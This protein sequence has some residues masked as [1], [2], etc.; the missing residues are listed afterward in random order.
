[1]TSAVRSL[2]AHVPPPPPSQNIHRAPPP[3]S[4][5]LAED[6][7]SILEGAA[8]A[9]QSSSSALGQQ[10]LGPSPQQAER[11][12]RQGLAE[13][14][15]SPLM[16]R[17]QVREKARF[18]R[19]LG[20]Y[21]L[22]RAKGI[23]VSSVRTV[24]PYM[25][26][27]DC[28]ETLED[29]SGGCT[30][31][32]IEMR[33]YAREPLTEESLRQ[34][35]ICLR[36]RKYRT[37][38]CDRKE[39][40]ELHRKEYVVI[41]HPELHF[42]LLTGRLHLCGEG[43]CFL[44]QTRFNHSDGYQAVCP[45]TGIAACNRDGVLIGSEF[46]RA[47]R[48]IGQGSGGGGGNL[49]SAFSVTQ[50][51][52]RHY[53]SSADDLTRLMDMLAESHA[54]LLSTSTSS[55]EPTTVPAIAKTEPN[56]GSLALA[57][58]VE[59]K[60]KKAPRKRTGKHRELDRFI[61]ARHETGFVHRKKLE[62]RVW[63]DWAQKFAEWDLW[64]DML[65]SMDS[66]QKIAEHLRDIT[67]ESYRRVWGLKGLI[68]RYAA[69]MVYVAFCPERYMHERKAMAEEITQSVKRLTSSM[70]S[71]GG[72]KPM[73]FSQLVDA[74]M[75]ALTRTRRGDVYSDVR[76]TMA[77]TMGDKGQ[78]LSL[79]SGKDGDGPPGEDVSSKSRGVIVAFDPE[80]QDPRGRAM[81]QMRAQIEFYTNRVV[82][83]W[84]I[85][86]ES[87]APLVLASGSTGEAS[88]PVEFFPLSH[89]VF[90]ALDCFAD[91]LCVTLNASEAGMTS[92]GTMP[93]F[94]V[95]PDGEMKRHLPKEWDF[96][97]CGLYSHAHCKIVQSNMA[98]AITSA[99]QSGRMP[100]DFIMTYTREWSDLKLETMPWIAELP[101][102]S[103][104]RPPPKKLAF[105]NTQTPSGRT[106][107]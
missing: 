20:V 78:Q 103:I 59:G 26:N 45:I 93:W 3:S 34:A 39:D 19:P 30:R 22:A 71:S 37:Y 106:I 62:S 95:P 75:G 27:H 17:Q 77:L 18:N 53:S 91:G 48:R 94:A 1:M 83:L 86:N 4:S 96:V 15:S 46:W 10:E 60:I 92:Q 58:A 81:G 84:V 16:S 88:S 14:C 49:G 99:M 7:L 101:N 5:R 72:D 98:Y 76:P 67:Q 9:S 102:K 97:G 87:C 65:C 66:F 32:Q 47:G 90:G 74:A 89:F 21:F 8:R 35:H 63:L 2:P 56:E 40:A 85:V 82:Q 54:E 25:P 29:G 33:V 23:W 61:A 70:S 73:I 13:A 11:L 24:N 31:V 51:N 6:A 43:I 36:D 79:T 105:V 38:L 28:M 69:A 64:L 55:L 42:C 68:K 12:L 50:Q 80:T 57:L 104:F 100:R 52:Q 41:D 107:A 44:A